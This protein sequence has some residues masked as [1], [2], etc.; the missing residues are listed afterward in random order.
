MPIDLEAELDR[1]YGVDLAD[2]VAERTRLA[3]ALRTEGRRVE[4]DRVKGLRKPSLSVW[5]VNQLAR[6]RPKEME[7][8][9]D[10]GGRLAVAQRALLTG[11]DKAAFEHASEAEREALDG[12]A[13]AARSLLGPK[14]SAATLD[15]MIVTLGAAAVSD[16]ARPELERGRLTSDVDFTGFDAFSGAAGAAT[17]GTPTAKS[18]RA[19]ESRPEREEIERAAAAKRALIA[20][21]RSEVK[22]ATEHEESAAT[23]LHEAE[24]AERDARA[25]HEQAQHAVTRYRADHQAAASALAAARAHLEQA[26]RSGAR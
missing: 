14:G 21:V 3:R 4:A 12:L 18:R 23:R 25:A 16:S 26:Q 22:S 20:Q 7:L 17:S 19:D 2:F 1:L 5:A 24:R 6:T 15:R 10:A 13:R 11:G 9:L 8:L